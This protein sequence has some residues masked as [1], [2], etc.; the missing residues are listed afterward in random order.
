MYKTR[1]DMII[2]H[3]AGPLA[4]PFRCLESSRICYYILLFF[5]QD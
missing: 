4:R 1:F 3:L 5:Y 2:L